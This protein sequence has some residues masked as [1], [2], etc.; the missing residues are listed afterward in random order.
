MVNR[1]IFRKIKEEMSS[2]C[3]YCQEPTNCSLTFKDGSEVWCCKK[4]ALIHGKVKRLKNISAQAQTLENFPD[5]HRKN[6]EN[7]ISKDSHTRPQGEAE[8][9]KQSSS[10]SDF[11]T[12]LEIEQEVKR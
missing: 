8:S 6:Q 2:P 12:A 4:D 5:S 3:W 1:G 9:L 7:S 11:K 10:P